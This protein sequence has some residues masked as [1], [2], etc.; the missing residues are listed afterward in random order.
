MHDIDLL[1]N[2]LEALNAYTRLPQR[3]EAIYPAL[4]RKNDDDLFGVADRLRAIQQICGDQTLG[5]LTDL[6]GSSGYFSLSLVDCG[7]ADRSAV[8]DVNPRALAAG[9]AMARLL[10]LDTLV[11]FHE[12]AIDL[13]FV[14][15]MSSADT[16]LCLNLL[17]H[18]GALFDKDEVAMVGWDRYVTE[19]LTELRSKSNLLIFGL[20]FKVRKPPHW[21]VP[22]AER[23][24]EFLKIVER[25]GWRVMYEANVEDIRTMGVAAADGHRSKGGLERMLDR[26]RV[27]GVKIDSSP[28]KRNLYH[29][30]ILK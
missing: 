11:S 1:K 10:N 3:L 5:T 9:G 30:Y 14:R 19:W 4:K 26:L 2:E 16:I 18:A 12:Q 7:M 15:E 21:D 25:S 20:G 8:Y 24:K 17:H 22:P 6:G 23:P 13:R 28:S 27:Q 29:L